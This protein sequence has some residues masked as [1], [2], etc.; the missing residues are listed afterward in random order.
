MIMR[1]LLSKADKN[2]VPISG[3]IEITRCCN[4]RCKHCYVPQN[5]NSYMC[6]ND[7][8]GYLGQ[9][10]EAGCRF[11]T[12]TGGE[13]LLN[14]DFE[15][16]YKY[17]I[18]KGFV[19][20]LYTNGTLIKDEHIRLFK[21]Y[22]PRFVE[23]TIYG[24]SEDV[25]ENVTGNREGFK[26]VKENIA[27][28]LQN[29][30]RVRLKT[31]INKLNYYDFENIAEFC[32]KL[33]G[34]NDL[35]N[36]KYDYKIFPRID[37][38]VDNLS[39]QI[40]ADDAVELDRKYHLDYIERWKARMDDLRYYKSSKILCGCGRH[41][42]QIDVFGVMNLCTF[43]TY[44]GMSLKERSFIEVWEEF[45]KNLEEKNFLNEKENE[46]DNCEYSF[47]CDVCPATAYAMEGI[48]YGNAAVK[49]C[50]EI[51]QRKYEILMKNL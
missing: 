15:E 25:Y 40:S 19:T 5:E 20:S 30:I 29:N 10:K 45:G 31:F 37:G 11:L 34:D 47:L 9:A 6:K 12:I 7:Y 18:E 27:C 8:I 4:L 1:D 28:L 14:P 41:S 38:S 3:Q 16:I 26:H 22:P 35:E 21:K 50:C 36:F 49:Y 44:S 13:P 23:I 24:A 43:N 51:A 42:F 2:R 17:T 48:E 33:V 46:C 32:K 39:L